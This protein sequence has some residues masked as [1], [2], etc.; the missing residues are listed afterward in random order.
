MIL[1]WCFPTL[2][3]PQ[4]VGQPRFGLCKGS[5]SPPL[6]RR[7]ANQDFWIRSSPNSCGLELD[8]AQAW[9]TAIFPKMKWVRPNGALVC[10]VRDCAG[11]RSDASTSGWWKNWHTRFWAFEQASDSI[12]MCENEMPRNDV[13]SIP[14][15]D[16]MVTDQRVDLHCPFHFVPGF[17]W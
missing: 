11:R 12:Y 5:A 8:R 10:V 13:I 14:I 9:K 3:K 7:P 15:F 17:V 16:R 2:W 6:A 4:R 1:S